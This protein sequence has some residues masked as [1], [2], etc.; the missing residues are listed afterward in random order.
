MKPAEETK[1][2]EKPV[3]EV[4]A[5]EVPVESPAE[6]PAE[7][8]VTAEAA[9][10]TTPAAPVVAVVV[11]P[12][13][14]TFSLRKGR[15]YNAPRRS[16][17]P[18]LLTPEEI[19]EREERRNRADRKKSEGDDRPRKPFKKKF[20]LDGGR[21]RDNRQDVVFAVAKAQPESSPFAAL[22]GLK[23]KASDGQK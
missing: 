11:K 3:E 19:K 9:P 23:V 2:E 15:A 4:K 17:K 6:S 13:L 22:Q 16:P 1:A 18:D 21:G 10:A 20:D 12:E 14:A 8:A 7:A 5:A